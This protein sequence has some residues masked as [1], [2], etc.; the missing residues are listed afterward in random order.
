MIPTPTLPSLWSSSNQ[1]PDARQQ[2]DASFRGARYGQLLTH[3]SR[4]VLGR[5]AKGQAGVVQGS[6]AAPKGWQPA[7]HCDSVQQSKWEVRL[8]SQT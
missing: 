7:G 5:S 8:E 1:S 3:L 2:R 4:F 6:P